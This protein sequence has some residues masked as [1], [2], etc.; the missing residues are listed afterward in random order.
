MSSVGKLIFMFP[1]KP[2]YPAE[3]PAPKVEEN[4][5]FTKEKFAEVLAESVNSFWLFLD[6]DFK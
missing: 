4:F 3:S 5:S 1:D 6:L 2:L